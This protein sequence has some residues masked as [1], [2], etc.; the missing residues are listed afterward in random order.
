M[1][2]SRD[3]S[4]QSLEQTRE[5]RKKRDAGGM[6]ERREGEQVFMV[7]EKKRRGSAAR[8]FPDRAARGSN[9]TTE[10]TTYITDQY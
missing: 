5:N 1:R 2:G 10:I 9:R 8:A 7:V 6:M 4:E 3:P